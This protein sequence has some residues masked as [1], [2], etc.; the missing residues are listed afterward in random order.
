[1]CRSVI[2]F[3]KRRDSV[4]LRV[5]KPT[6]VEEGVKPERDDGTFRKVDIYIYKKRDFTPHASNFS[7]EADTT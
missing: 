5:K 6:I 3:E 4:V 7:R 2:N 1:M